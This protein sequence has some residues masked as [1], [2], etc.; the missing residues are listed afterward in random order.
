MQKSKIEINSILSY[1]FKKDLKKK[2]VSM[3]KKI[4]KEIAIKELYDKKN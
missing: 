2:K 3:L 4:S 1:F